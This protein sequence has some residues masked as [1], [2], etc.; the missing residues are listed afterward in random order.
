MNLIF[1]PLEPQMDFDCIK[2]SSAFDDV[3]KKND[4]EYANYKVAFFV[5][6]RVETE[7]IN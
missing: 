4:I 5:G 3:D 1:P 7:K 2:V 6:S